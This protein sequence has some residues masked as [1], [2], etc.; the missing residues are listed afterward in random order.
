MLDGPFVICDGFGNA[1]L[2]QGQVA[3][4]VEQGHVNFFT[5][6]F[7]LFNRTGIT[8]YCTIELLQL[9]VFDRLLPVFRGVRHQYSSDSRNQPR[10]RETLIIAGLFE[11][12]VTDVLHRSYSTG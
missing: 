9:F 7:I 2:A 5:R 10:D 8:R 3:D 12:R 11:N 6:I 4:L 1:S